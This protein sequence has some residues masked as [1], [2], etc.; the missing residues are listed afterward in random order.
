MFF[1]QIQ[2][3][4]LQFVTQAEDQA[5]SKLAFVKLVLRQVVILVAFLATVWYIFFMTFSI[6][7]TY[8]DGK[9]TT[10]K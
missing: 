7:E 3:E 8:P 2:E 9:F 4:S 5:D 6:V 1:L 10:I